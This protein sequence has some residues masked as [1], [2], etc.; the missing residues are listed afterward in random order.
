MVICNFNII[1][2][3]INET[4][5]YAPLVVY[6]YCMLSVSVVIQR[7]KAV[8]RRGFKIINTRCKVNIFESAYSSSEKIRF[9]LSR[10]PSFKKIFCMFI[11]KGLYHVFAIM[12]HVTIVKLYFASGLN[13][14]HTMGGSVYAAK[15]GFY[16]SIFGSPYGKATRYLGNSRA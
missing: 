12:C 9:K 3:A 13:P 10:F 4:E 15:T 2:I 6:R 11:G 5:A 16:P 8:T 14:W 7:V 1:R